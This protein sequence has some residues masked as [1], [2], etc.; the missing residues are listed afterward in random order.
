MNT[1]MNRRQWLKRSAAAATGLLVAP[2]FIACRRQSPF[3]RSS[4]E[5]EEIVLLD[6][7]ESPYGMPPEAREAV[8]DSLARA[9]RYPHKMYSAL[10]ALIAEKE[11][12]PKDH[13]ILGAGST[14]VMN[15]AI[16]SYGVK[17]EIVTADPTYF[18][19]IFYAGQA[20]CR[21]RKV[22]VSERY[23]L[24]L[25]A[26]ISRMSRETSLVYVCNPNNPT[27][28][29][30]NKRKLRAFCEEVSKK[31]LVVVDEAY[32]EYVEDEAYASMADLVREGMNV[33]VTRTFS[34]IFGMAGL[35]VGYGMARPDIQKN[36]ERVQ[37]NFASIA[38]PSLRAAIAAYGA[39]AFT[40]L[41][42]EKNRAVRAYLEKQLEG[43]G[44]SCIPSHAN[45][46]L[47]EVRRDPKEMAA[48]LAKHGILIRPFDFAGKSWLRV[49]V[50]TEGE[51]HAFISALEQI[52]LVAEGFSRADVAIQNWGQLTHAPNYSGVL[53]DT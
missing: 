53:P 42:R 4:P 7:N 10:A 39:S 45:F 35:R 46:S 1:R 52:E 43:L 6:N 32:H 19:F 27:G 31:A 47:F 15:M 25:D 29:I 40:S 23:E 5:T 26:M 2:E 30:V 44:Y 14:E 36:F 50:G 49:S 22:P 37:M 38:Y 48:D 41:V 17:G 20:K 9:N 11:G 24:D 18:D 51:I 21:I 12:L 34:K 3:S 33:A 8:L 13:V 28:A 16:L